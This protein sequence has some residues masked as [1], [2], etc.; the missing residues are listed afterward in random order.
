MESSRFSSFT[1]DDY[2]AVFDTL[3]DGS[4]KVKKYDSGDIA[5]LGLSNVAVAEE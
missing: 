1:E 2:E 3:A 4:V 5:S